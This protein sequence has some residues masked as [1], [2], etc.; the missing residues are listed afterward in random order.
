[1]K[2]SKLLIL[3]MLMACVASSLDATEEQGVSSPAQKGKAYEEQVLI[4][5]KWG[6]KPGEYKYRMWEGDLDWPRSMVVDDNEE[7]YILDHLNN[8][9]QHYDKNGKFLGVI[10]IDSYKLA[11]NE[12]IKRNN[13]LEYPATSIREIKYIDGAIYAVKDE[14]SGTKRSETL[15][16][17]SKGRFSKVAA[18]DEETKVRNKMSR[19]FRIA[20]IK[21]KLKADSKFKAESQKRNNTVSERLTYDGFDASFAFEDQSKHKWFSNGRVIRA[22]GPNGNMLFEILKNMETMIIST[23]A[24]LYLLGLY[25]TKPSE[26]QE[27]W[28]F[29]GYWE[30]ISVKK[31]IL[32]K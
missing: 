22:Y 14:R 6:E 32:K 15:H 9:V 29:E 10:P 26:D 31:I 23:Q 1:M 17:F 20:E 11:S 4:V 16:K 25:S 12:D 8:R 24:N 19:S 5:G 7:I 13:G 27:K 2:F 28:D 18:A 30:G 3:V 21:E